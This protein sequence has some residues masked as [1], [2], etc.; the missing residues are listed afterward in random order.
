MC[1]RDSRQLSG[2]LT[3]YV[4]L[5]LLTGL[6][7]ILE[8]WFRSDSLGAVSTSYRGLAFWFIFALASECFWVSLPG[9][10]GMVSM[11]LAADLAMLFALPVPHALLIA[12]VS[13]AVADLLPHRRGGTRAFFNSAQT[14]ISLAVAA[15]VM[16]LIEGGIAAPGSGS[17]LRHPIAALATLPVFCI[18]NTM[19]VSGAIALESQKSLWRAWRDSFGFIYHYQSCTIL[20]AL[21]L[22]LVVAVEIAGYACGLV[23]LFFLFAL[24]DAYR[25][26]TRKRTERDESE[27]TKAAA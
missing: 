12:G 3:I 24:R 7:L 20:F 6:V 15:M 22:Q 21:G 18:L 2:S 23:A 13:V 17:F 8:S 5:V 19:L 10:R 14:V 16:R 27:E 1:A 11:G 26:Q 4:S 25:Y 9:D